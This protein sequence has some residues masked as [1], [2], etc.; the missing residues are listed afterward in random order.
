MDSAMA[1]QLQDEED[2]AQIQAVTDSAM[3]AELQDE[4]EKAHGTA[5][6]PPPQAKAH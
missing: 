3:A 2:K 1:A 4:E 6:T 5:F